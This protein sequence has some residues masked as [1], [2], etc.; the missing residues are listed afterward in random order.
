M[1]TPSEDV[2]VVSFKQMADHPT[3][4]DEEVEEYFWRFQS[5]LDADDIKEVF[6]I[7]AGKRPRLLARLEATYAT[8]VRLN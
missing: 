8:G 6:A 1:R 7:L 3:V 5:I 2:L 4:G